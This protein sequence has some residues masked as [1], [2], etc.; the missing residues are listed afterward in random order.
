MWVMVDLNQD[1]SQEY[2][3]KVSMV[4]LLGGTQALEL[5]TCHLGVRPGRIRILFCNRFHLPIST[6]PFL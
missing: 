1:E 3:V 6:C 4:P 2:Y 5:Q